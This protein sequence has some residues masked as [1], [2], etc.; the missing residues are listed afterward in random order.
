GLARAVHRGDRAQIGTRS[1]PDREQLVR[2]AVPPTAAAAFL[3]GLVR[4]RYELV[5]EAA[6]RKNKLTAICDELFPEFT[7]VLKDPNAPGALADLEALRVGTHP[8]TA[9]L[10]GLQAAA[11][12]T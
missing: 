12:T 10:G 7:D 4:H 8:S 3:R 9:K 5:R 2:R 6:R 11:A 1:G